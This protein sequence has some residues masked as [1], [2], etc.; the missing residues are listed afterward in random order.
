MFASLK[1]RRVIIT[2]ASKGI[3]RGMAQRFALAGC[4]V[5]VVARSLSSAHDVV[6]EI[7]AEGGD[8]VAFQ[9]NVTVQSDML[10]MA[11]AAE[12]RFGGIDI[13]CANA[14]IFPAAPLSSMTEADFDGVMATNLK[15]TFL[16]VQACLTALKATGKGRII[17]TSSITGP[18]TGYTGWSHYGASKAGQLGFMRTAAIELAPFGITVNAVLPG[19]IATEGLAGMGEDYARSMAA[20]VPMKRLGSVTDIANAALFFASDEAAY[21]TGQSLIVDGGQIL[22]ESPAAMAD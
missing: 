13:L 11:A 17:L 10:A 19:N 9:G 1:N 4:R 12:A 7:A 8:A 6:K 15:G 18:V 22:P 2:G 21:I 20:S 5:L 14:G 3:G 16:A